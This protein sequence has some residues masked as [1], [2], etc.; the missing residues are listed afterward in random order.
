MPRNLHLNKKAVNWCS[1]RL[2]FMMNKSKTI[3][4]FPR[5]VHFP[6]AIWSQ[7]VFAGQPPAVKPFQ[8]SWYS[9]TPRDLVLMRLC[10]SVL[11]GFQ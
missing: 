7:G 4:W 3:R 6:I 11:K 10:C 8:N 1:Q 5:A 9:I 2:A